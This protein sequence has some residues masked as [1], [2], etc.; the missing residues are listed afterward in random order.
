MIYPYAFFV[1]ILFKIE[2]FSANNTLKM[3]FFG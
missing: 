1:I 3:D 2:D